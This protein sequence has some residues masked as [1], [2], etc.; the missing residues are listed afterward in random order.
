MVHINIILL[1]APYLTDVT[2]AFKKQYEFEEEV[3]L[4]VFRLHP[5]FICDL[6]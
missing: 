5:M 2:R 3:F 4:V 6:T 1:Y